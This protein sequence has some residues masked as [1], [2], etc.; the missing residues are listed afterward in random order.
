MQMVVE[1]T[2]P[3]SSVTYIGSSITIVTKLVKFPYTRELVHCLIIAQ[4][5]DGNARADS[6]AKVVVP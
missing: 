5:R 3:E 2:L 4:D 1:L 6:A